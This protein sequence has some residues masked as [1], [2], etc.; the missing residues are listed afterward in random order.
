MGTRVVLIKG[1][2]Q[3]IGEQIRKGA[4][5][6]GGWNCG[7]RL[8]QRNLKVTQKMAFSCWGGSPN[9]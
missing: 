3:L 4:T 5:P 2:M 8:E 1:S 9:N 6:S 7:P